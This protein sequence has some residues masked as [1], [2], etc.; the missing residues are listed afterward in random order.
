MVWKMLNIEGKNLDVLHACGC[1]IKLLCITHEPLMGNMTGECGLYFG[2][3]V[4]LG[5]NEP[6]TDHGFKVSLI[7]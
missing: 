1:L 2:Y 7:R 3:V 4:G 6:S 5:W